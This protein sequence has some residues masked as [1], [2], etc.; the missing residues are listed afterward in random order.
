MKQIKL[1][2]KPKH[3]YLLRNLDTGYFVPAL[4][5][6]V[7]FDPL[8]C[9]TTRKEAEILKADTLEKWEIETEIV[10]VF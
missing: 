3:V 2:P 10:K 1:Q 5:D 4:D 9:C 8:I 7:E 6:P